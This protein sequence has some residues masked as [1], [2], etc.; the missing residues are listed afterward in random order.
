MT[1]D[2]GEDFVD[3]RKAFDAS[4]HSVLL[5]KNQILDVAGDL[6]C[7]ITDYLSGRTQVTT[8]NGCQSQSM[9]VTFGVPQGSVLGPSLFPIYCIDLP[10]I[11]DGIDDDP[12]LYM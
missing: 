10:N 12:L 6:W 9:P 5:R 1:G 2:E 7:W 3:F 4:P 8:I 11:I